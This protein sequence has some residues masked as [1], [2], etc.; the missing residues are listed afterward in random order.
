[1]CLLGTLVILFLRPRDQRWQVLVL[2]SYINALCIASG[3]ASEIR[4]A[5]SGI[6][7]HA[8]IWMFLPLSLHL[9]LILPNALTEKRFRIVVPLYV[10]SIVF[11]VLDNCHL[12]SDQFEYY[13]SF[14]LG[15]LG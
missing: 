3:M 6:V 4:V 1:F 12:L 8:V 2:F 10:V 5:G 15:V 7:F 13:L 11:A 9:H 14:T